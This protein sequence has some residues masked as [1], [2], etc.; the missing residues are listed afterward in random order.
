VLVS[1]GGDLRV[2]GPEPADGW[3]VLVQDGPDQPA[4]RIRLAGARALATSSTLHRTWWQAGQHRHHVLD[5][6]TGFPADPVWRTASV[7]AA[8]CLEANTLSTA[9]LVRGSAAPA[10]LRRAGASARLV[11]AG[12]DVLTFGGWPR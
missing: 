11:A 9:A 1:L 3:T 12:G 8:S 6:A 10:L 5:P 4:S 2:A 7:A